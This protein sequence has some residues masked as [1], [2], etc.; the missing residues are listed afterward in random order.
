MLALDSRLEALMSSNDAFD[1]LG[2]LPDGRSTTVLEASAG[3]GKTWTVGALV[4]RYV[5][6]GVATLDEM[7]VITFGRAASQELRER[8]REQLV[9]A[10]RALADPAS[11]ESGNQLLAHLVSADVDVRRKRIIDAL[12]GFD[13]ATIATTHQFCQLV[14]RSL[15][16]AGD[17]D[18][19]AELVESLDDLVVEVT[20]DL[21]LQRWGSAPEPP[22]FKRPVALQLARAAI[23]D[24]QAELAPDDAEAGSLAETKVAFA[25]DVRAE[26]ERRKHRRG[27]LSYDDLLSRL[28]HALREEDAPARERM[29][30]RWKVVLVDEFQDTDP[31]QWDVLDRAFS[32]H[33]TLVLIGDPKQAIYA[34]RGGDVVTYL[35]AAATA[36]TK[37]TLATNWRSDA[38]LV[39]ALQRL[40]L[41]AE[42][43]DPSITVHD[44]GA[45]HQTSRLVGAPA[46]AAAPGPAAASRR[47]HDRSRRHRPHRRAAR[48]HRPRPRRRRR[49]A[50]RLGRHLRRPTRAGRRRRAAPLQRQAG[51]AHPARPGSPRHP[52]GRRRRQQRAAQPRGRRVARPARGARATAHQPGPGRRADLVR[53]GDTAP[54]STPAGTRWPTPSRS[55]C[56]AGSTCSAPAGWPRST[57]RCARPACPD[58]CSRSPTAS[59]C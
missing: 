51:G 54:R 52:L 29:R 40:T 26:V 35:K 9:E 18:S 55:G 46:P 13:G 36:S 43:G 4:A 24:P 30:R 27:V 37:Q 31:V 12:A 42:L 22:P 21:F 34:F 50:A 1:V 2:P 16:V 57:R 38:P 3:T 45:H 41:G 25:R 47:L 32:G 49:P 8:V 17:T 39:D 14:L 15:G 5:A 48:A 28:A 6:E 19:R 59:G 11:V 23:G 53:R 58:A 10:E 56:A 44:V 7:L 20:D 33:A